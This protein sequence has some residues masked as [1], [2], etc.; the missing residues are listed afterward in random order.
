MLINDIVVSLFTAHKLPC[1]VMDIALVM[2]VYTCNDIHHVK[3]YQATTASCNMVRHP[4]YI[5][6]TDRKRYNV[7]VSVQIVVYAGS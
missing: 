2:Y 5:D 6:L 1:N 7:H 3:P 4:K